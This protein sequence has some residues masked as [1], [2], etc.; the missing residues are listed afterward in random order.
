M[1]ETL[2]AMNASLHEE[3]RATLRFMSGFEQVF[4]TVQKARMIVMAGGCFVDVVALSAE[5][6]GQ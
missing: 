5:M 3:Y 4:D 2:N 6:L 1:R